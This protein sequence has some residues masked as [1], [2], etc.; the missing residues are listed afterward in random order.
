MQGPSKEIAREKTPDSS[1]DPNLI[2]GVQHSLQTMWGNSAIASWMRELNGSDI[3]REGTLSSPSD[4][5][6]GTSIDSILQQQQENGSTLSSEV[7]QHAFHPKS[8]ENNPESGMRL[9]VPGLNTPETED[10]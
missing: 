10:Q 6:K 7:M 5:S 1:K 9:F 4:R 8:G 3:N 2:E